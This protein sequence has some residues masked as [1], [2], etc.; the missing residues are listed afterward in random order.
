MRVLVTG[1]SGQ[2]GVCLQ[3]D[4]K[5]TGWNCLA[6]SRSQLDISNRD[7]VLT[8]VVG[9]NPDLI[10]NAAAY[11]AVDK[12]E[13]D[14]DL[15]YRINRDGPGYLAEAAK[16]VDAAIFHISTD[17]VFSGDKTGAYLESDDCNP[18][19]V[20]GQSK[21]EGE[22]A[23]KNACSEHIILRTSWVF[24][25]HGANFVKTMLRLGRERSELSVVSDQRGGPT[26]AGDISKALVQL[27]QRLVGDCNKSADMRWGIY[28]YSGYPYVSWSQF[29]SEIFTRGEKLSLLPSVVQVNPITTDQYPT[30][31]IRPANSCLDCSSIYDA[32]GISPSNW[33]AALDDLP[34]YLA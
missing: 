15:A 18:Q 20:Y 21:R 31:A 25:E 29:A 13:A 32:Y 28:N 34:L 6:L 19:S 10:I 12:A 17:Y 9:F 4:L 2:V 11:T 24:A 7:N 33:R 30:P 1:A 27:A 22:I 5:D 3:R 14:V 26:Y 8:S 16:A 23:V